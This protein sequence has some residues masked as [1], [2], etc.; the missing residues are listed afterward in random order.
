MYTQ[1]SR[2]VEVTDVPQFSQAIPM[3]G[4]NTVAFNATVMQIT[5]TSTLTISIQGSNDLENWLTLAT[6]DKTFD[7]VGY[8][9][10]KNVGIADAYV[11]LVY[12][13]G[14]SEQAIVS[15][16]MNLAEL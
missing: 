15:A 14:S 9:K 1:L 5:A 10:K 3:E 2:N 16:G 8:G 13:M 11:R 12:S 4:A 6:T 7:A